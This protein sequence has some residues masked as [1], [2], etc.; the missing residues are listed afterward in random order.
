MHSGPT[1]SIVSRSPVPLHRAHTQSLTGMTTTR[2]GGFAAVATFCSGLGDLLTRLS[3]VNC[4][5]EYGDL[6]VL[7]AQLSVA[8]GALDALGDE[9]G[10][11]QDAQVVGEG[12]PGRRV[13]RLG[14]PGPGDLTRLRLREG[15]GPCLA[16]GHVHGRPVSDEIL[17]PGRAARRS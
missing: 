7:L 4:V 1:S 16:C 3:V 6:L 11:A 15:P 13:R 5:A 17:C 10:L 9:A 12:R 2:S 8:L 14:E